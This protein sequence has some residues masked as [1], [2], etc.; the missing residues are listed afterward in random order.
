MFTARYVLHSTFC[1]HSVFMCFVWIWEQTAIILLYSIDWLF[2]VIETESVY[3]AVRSTF[4]VFPTQW[5]CVFTDLRAS[6]YY[7]TDC[8]LYPK[9]CVYCAVRTEYLNR[10]KFNLILYVVNNKLFYLFW[11]FSELKNHFCI[12]NISVECL[13]SAV[14]FQSA[15]PANR[16]QQVRT[17]TKRKPVFSSCATVRLPRETTVIRSSLSWKRPPQTN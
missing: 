17:Y 5:I 3:C 13:Q 7:L 2:F 11:Y 15:C 6:S 1:P 14:T 10:I 8:F 4:S 16:Y 9:H 12:P